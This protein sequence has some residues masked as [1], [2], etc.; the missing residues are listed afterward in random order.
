MNPV[1]ENAQTVTQAHHGADAIPDAIWAPIS[2]GILTLI[3]GLLGFAT[4]NLWLFPSLGPSAYL[5]AATP[6]NEAA[7]PYNTFVGHICGI[8]AALLAVFLCGANG[9][10]SVFE[11]HHLILSRLI[12]SAVAVALTLLLGV[13]LKAQ[14]PPAAATTLLI[15]LG[16]FKPNFNDMSALV[17][18]IVIITV[19]GEL[20]RRARLVQ[21]GQK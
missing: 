12:A 2:G 11:V 8:A 21:P 18:G 19:A 1:A 9:A 7:R 20:M 10:P 16:G 13:L 4:G 3:P 6:Q 14:H 5:Q 17:T 15:T